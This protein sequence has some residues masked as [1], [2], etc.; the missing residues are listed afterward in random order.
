MQF[1]SQSLGWADCIIL[2]MAPL[3]V[4]TIIFSAIRVDGPPWLKAIIGRS[5]EN[6]LVAEMELMSSTSEETCELWN[7][8][9]MVRC[10]G[11]APVKEFICILPRNIPFS[12]IKRVRIIGLEDEE[13]NPNRALSSVTLDA[14]TE[15]K[16]ILQTIVALKEDT[17]RFWIALW[18]RTSFA[19]VE[20]SPII[21]LHH[22]PQ[23]NL[24]QMG[25]PEMVILRNTTKQAPNITLNR[26]N[27][28]TRRHLYIAA[29]FVSAVQV[30]VLIYFGLIT[31]YYPS[32]FK[33]EDKAVLGYAFPFSAAGTVLLVTG[34][35]LC[36]HV[37]DRS[38]N[39]VRYVPTQGY[40]SFALYPEE[41]PQIIT[42]SQRH[43]SKEKA[44][45]KGGPTPRREEVSSI[46]LS[47][48]GTGISLAG[49]FVQFIGL[50]AM[51]WSASVAQLTAILIMTA[52]R[53][54]VRRGFTASIFDVS[55]K[56]RFESD[57]LAMATGTY[58]SKTR[59]RI[60]RQRTNIRLWIIKGWKLDSDDE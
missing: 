12:E 24:P 9:D 15:E 58:R 23:D 19:D 11:L 8:D 37:V 25:E 30:A 56:E 36:A 20:A 44:K 13:N 32:K 39:E 7:G 10:Q 47:V 43:G 51:H 14:E 2:A 1:L 27:K 3:G 59:L 48:F 40:E 5:R 6:R 52:V 41:C 18:S 4:I 17:K 45:G 46:N 16:R 50:R 31:Y 38:T 33:K 26:H 49:F 57:G 34:R 21:P 22:L 35:F 42:T 28:V 60:R 53:A 55:L 54:F 29:V